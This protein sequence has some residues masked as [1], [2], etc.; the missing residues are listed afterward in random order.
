[1]IISQ[2]TQ[3]LDHNVNALCQLCPNKKIQTYAGNEDKDR[4]AVW[5]YTAL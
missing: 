1:M 4:T 2:Y 5:G 3:I